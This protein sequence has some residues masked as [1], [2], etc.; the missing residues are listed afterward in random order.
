MKSRTPTLVSECSVERLSR[1]VWVAVLGSAPVHGGAVAGEVVA[2]LSVA[3]KSGRG[4]YEPD[5]L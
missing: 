4:G 5:P 1:S 3:G 2:R